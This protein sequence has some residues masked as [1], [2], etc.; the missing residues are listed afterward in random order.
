VLLH[1][2][3]NGVVYVL[4]R[5]SGAILSANRFVTVNATDG[6]D[7][8]SGKPQRNPA[9]AAHEN[10]TTSIRHGRVRPADGASSLFTA[11]RP[12]V[13]TRKPGSAWT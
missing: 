10:A 6:V 12:I 5:P 3:A 4:D 1:P 13:Y 11:N 2:D 8:N 9:K 7:I